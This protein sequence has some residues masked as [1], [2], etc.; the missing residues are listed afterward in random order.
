MASILFSDNTER[1]RLQAMA[2]LDQGWSQSQVARHFAVTPAAVC[3][4]VKAFQRAGFEALKARPRSGAP[5]KLTNS[6]LK[7]ME[8]LL[9][10]GPTK[11]GYS[12]ELWTLQRIVE[13]IRKHFGVTYDPSGV[14]HILRRMGWTCQKPERRGRQR[15]EEAIAMWRKQR[16]PNIKK[17]P[18]KR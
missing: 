1:R 13:I 8:K 3:Q 10:S 11:Q 15:D 4:W 14:W 17:R 9:L 7:Q 18:A 5:P 2:L 6:Q 16:W 12:T